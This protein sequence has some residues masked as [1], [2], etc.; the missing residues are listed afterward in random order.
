MNK[1]LL[2]EN[3]ELRDTAKKGSSDEKNGSL[4]MPVPI[5]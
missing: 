3:K 2:D 1:T 5:H 4:E